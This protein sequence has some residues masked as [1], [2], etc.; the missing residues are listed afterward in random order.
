[1]KLEEYLGYDGLGLAE[2]VK[3]KEVTAEELLAVAIERA[4]KVNPRINAIINPLY[5][6]GRK[7]AADTSQGDFQGVPFLLKDLGAPLAGYPMSHGSRM[8]RYYVPSQDGTLVKRFKNT[9]LVIFGKTNTPE[10]GLMGTTEPKYFGPTRNPWNTDYSTG[11]SSGGSAAAIAAGITPIASAGDGGGSIRIPAA[12]CGLFGL[13][14]SR[15]RV[16]LGPDRSEDWDGAVVEHIL[17]RSVRDSAVML[18]RVCGP[19]SGDPYFLPNPEIPYGDVIK[20]DPKPLRV[21]YCTRSPLQN[22]VHPECVEA[23]EDFARKLASLGHIVEEASPA[24]DGMD[25]A[26]AYLTI[27][28][29]QVGAQ[30]KRFKRIYGKRAVREG[31]EEAT[32]IFGVLGNALPATDYVEQKYQWNLFGRIM[33]DFHETY[34]LYLTPA[35]AEPPAKIGTLPPTSLEE[36]GLRWVEKLRAG[37]LLLK[38]GIVE[39]LSLESLEK[40]PFTQLGNLTGQPGMSLPL[41]WSSQGLPIGVQVMSA[42]GREDLLFGLAG[43]VE[44]AFPWFDNLP[45]LN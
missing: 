4:E 8:L 12:S 30:I 7:M 5:D 25:V 28:V 44:R 15:G 3:K 41:Y 20:Q 1:M 10:F 21:A 33:G 32:R 29:G 2:L 16:S 34:D 43:Q 36:F 9:G 37:R 23:V 31:L 26:K 35:L 18:D 27:Y 17:S 13:K 24:I 6:L 45:V 14:P 22:P 39:K 40:A 11:G 19:A 38:T 42:I